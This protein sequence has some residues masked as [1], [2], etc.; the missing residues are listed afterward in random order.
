M[1][2]LMF[3]VMI[4]SEGSLSPSLPHGLGEGN[5]RGRSESSEGALT[6]LTPASRERGQAAALETLPAD[7]AGPTVLTGVG[8]AWI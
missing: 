3:A 7:E 8:Q 6:V 4:L 2:D 5:C 1:H